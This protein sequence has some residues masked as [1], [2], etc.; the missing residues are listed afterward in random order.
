MMYDELILKSFHQFIISEILELLYLRS[1]EHMKTRGKLKIMA[2]SS[3]LRK[4]NFGIIDL[5]ESQTQKTD[6]KSLYTKNKY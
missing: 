4:T 3:I 5:L 1:Q 2:Y 6:P